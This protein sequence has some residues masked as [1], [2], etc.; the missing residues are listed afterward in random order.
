M[1]STATEYF[2][3]LFKINEN[4]NIPSLAVLL[5]KTENIYN[6]DLNSRTVEAPE[7]LS[8]LDDHDS[9]TVYF[10]VDRFFDNMDLS[11]T[12]CVIQYINAN[13]EGR[14][15]AVPYYD[16]ETYH[17]SNKML[18][19]WCIDG[20]ATKAAGEVTYSIRFFKI[21][22]DGKYL[23]YNL[24]T[25]PATSKVLNGI[26]VLDGYIPV[27][28]D[29][30]AFKADINTFYVLNADGTYTP[31][32][33]WSSTTQYYT[34]TDGYNYAD[35]TLDELI[36]RIATLERETQTYWYDATTRDKM[37]NT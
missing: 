23:V 16:I 4:G 17:A 34:L 27:E 13:K 35:K 1:I 18:I 31:A 12:A 10:I 14:I 7:F 30:E 11:T 24:N 5:P 22:D 3:A 36:A 37:L 28:V 32:T 29:E 25:L 21:S 15:Y 33:S 6:I 8:V 20:E 19:P 26:N 2:E 9:E